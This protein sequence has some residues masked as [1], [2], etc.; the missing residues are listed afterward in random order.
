MNCWY[1]VTRLWTCAGFL[2]S[3]S[4]EPLMLRI[5]WPNPAPFTMAA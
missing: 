4:R 5:V 3:H 2:P 1:F